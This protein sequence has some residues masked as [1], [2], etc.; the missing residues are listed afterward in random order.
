MEFDL[1][2]FI[3]ARQDNYA[4]ALQELSDGQKRSHWMWFIF[5]QIHG[6]G[7]SE[8]TRFYAISGHS[9]A[10]AYLKYPVLGAHLEECTRSMLSHP[11]P[12]AREILG[13][14]D[15]LKFH[16]SVTLFGIAAQSGSPFKTAL[17]VFYGGE[18]D[19]ATLAA[20]KN[21]V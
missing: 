8:T 9:E 16:S 3:K 11:S 12:T 1:V 21:Y 10:E 14:P 13:S 2:R 19:Q 7:R 4:E 18:G 5:P 6:L 15:D 20:L 17:H